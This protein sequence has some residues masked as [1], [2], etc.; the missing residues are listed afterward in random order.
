MVGYWKRNVSV[1]SP[2][3]ILK[4]PHAYRILKCPHA[5]IAQ[6][7][8]GIK[9]AVRAKPKRFWPKQF[10][11]SRS[12]SEDY[13]ALSVTSNTVPASLFAAPKTVLPKQVAFGV[14]DLT[15]LAPPPSAQLAC[16]QKLTRLLG[17]L[18]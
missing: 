15:A 16:E 13:E 1:R 12:A 2:Y 7:R 17:V 18:A 11:F 10:G 8:S 14:G 5:G 6:H 3:R 9:P 4:C